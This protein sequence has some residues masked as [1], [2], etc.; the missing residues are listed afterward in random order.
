MPWNTIFSWDIS[1]YERDVNTVIMRS[2]PNAMLI[3]I[4]YRFKVSVRSFCFTRKS[5]ILWYCGKTIHPSAQSGEL[6]NVR[7]YSFQEENNILPKH[8]SRK[9]YPTKQAFT[10]YLQLIHT[11]L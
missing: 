8:V 7:Q 11:L 2:N 4:K 3:C 9:Q 6:E 5:L 1:L 10:I